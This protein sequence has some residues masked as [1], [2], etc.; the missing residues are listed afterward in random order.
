MHTCVNV[1]AI[2]GPAGAGKGTLGRR[3]AEHFRF[4]YLDTGLLYRGVGWA[5][6][7]RGDNP[8][9]AEAAGNAA[10]ALRPQDLSAPALRSDEAAAAASQVAV[11]RGVRAALLALQREFAR[12][13]PD[14]AAGAVLDGRDIGTV[15]C[16]EAPV[17]LF[18]TAAV[19]IRAARRVK[20]LQERG[21]PAIHERVLRDMRD[22]DARDS[23]RA[24][25]P[26]QPAEGAFVIDT[27]RLDPDAALAVALRHIAASNRLHAQGGTAT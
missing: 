9:N 22:R 10:A 3:L 2:D 25:A 14:G 4:A 18:V 16:P 27:G 24:V 13:P 7:S 15:V 20:E 6:L 23:S 21:R 17:K 12:R 1:I 11:H 8:A 5:V 26:L 19:E